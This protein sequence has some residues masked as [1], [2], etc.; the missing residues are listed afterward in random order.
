MKHIV[1]LAVLL[2]M[3]ACLNLWADG[4]VVTL[5]NDVF[6]HKDDNYT[7]GL[8]LSLL[9]Y[10]NDVNGEK[11]KEVWGWRNRMYTPEDITCSTNQPGDRPWAGVTT[12]YHE[13]TKMDGADA[14]MTGWEL[15][16]MGPESGVDWMQTTVHKWIGSR[17]PMGWSNQVPNE[18]SAQFYRTYYNSLA[19][20]GTS[21]H[22]MA[23]LEMP[24][25][26]CGGT[27]FDY[28]SAGISARAGWNLPPLHYSGT[29]EP[30]AILSKPFAYLLVDGS[31]RYMLHN[32]TLGHSFFRSYKDS[33]WDRDLIPLVGEWH[34][35]AC[36]GYEN[37]AITYLKEFRTDE[38]DGQPEPFRCGMIR[39]ELGITF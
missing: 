35:G 32:A 37:L 7:Q 17:T 18:V 2:A 24:Y 9:N 25:G 3:L 20:M 8:E 13:W 14:V 4:F 11:K 12:V 28:V 5:E 22:W 19:R 21:E 34:Y 6:T 39:L 15:G 10:D 1:M 38:F 36:I 30:K 27:T 29:I 16:V 23:D 31:A 33:T 26:F